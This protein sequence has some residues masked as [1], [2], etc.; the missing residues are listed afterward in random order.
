[1]M[2]FHHP[3]VRTVLLLLSVV[4]Q[5]AAP[6]A[7]AA[8]AELRWLSDIN[9]T[10]SNS[11][12]T[13]RLNRFRAPYT[14][15]EI[16]DETEGNDG[17][18]GRLFG[19]MNGFFDRLFQRWDDRKVLVPTKVILPLLVNSSAQVQTVVEMM[20]QESKA[21]SSDFVKMLLDLS[22]ENMESVGT[23]LDPIVA[24]VQQSNEQMD[25]R[26]LGCHMQPLAMVLRDVTVPNIQFMAEVAYTYLG[27]GDD[28]ND[29]TEDRFDAYQQAKT[30]F[31][32]GTATTT[33][34]TVN[35][36][37]CRVHG[38]FPSTPTTT[39]RLFSSMDIRASRAS[40]LL[41][42]DDCQIRTL[43][44]L[45]LFFFLVTI[46]IVFVIVRAIFLVLF[47]PV[48]LLW[49]IIDYVTSIGNGAITMDESQWYQQLFFGNN[50]LAHEARL[51]APVF[52]ILGNLSNIMLLIGILMPPVNQVAAESKEPSRAPVVAPSASPSMVA[53]STSPTWFETPQPTFCT[54]GQNEATTSDVMYR[55]S[56][57]LESPLDRIAA[58]FQNEDTIRDNMNPDDDQ[59]VMEC[60]LAQFLCHTNAVLE[61]LPL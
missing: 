27:G 46:G 52:D 59:D 10:C 38:A 1:M 9:A 4:F 29:N 6:V 54:P 60:E 55:L 53:P 44:F 15:V 35:D 8:S 28:D 23:M 42:L 11:C 47:W 39:A 58:V 49:F 18:F 32:A 37:I 22:A 24:S 20:R 40:G 61:A 41:P 12:E 17:L 45:L 2:K 14:Q 5:K 21:S 50:F 25:I 43:K 56:V 19:R 30:T 51:A 3:F 13:N 33:A 36:H 16:Q 34:D 48:I 57:A 26:T 7:D 31:A